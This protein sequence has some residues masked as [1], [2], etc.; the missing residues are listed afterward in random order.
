MAVGLSLLGVAINLLVTWRTDV[1]L[2]Q[3]AFDEAVSDGRQMLVAFADHAVRLL[4]YGDSHLR[5]ARAVYQR[6]GGSDGFRDFLAETKVMHSESLFVATTFSDNDGQIVFD[7]E[8][9]QVPNV[10]AAGLDYFTFFQTHDDDVAYIDPTRF[11]RVWQ[12]YLF[13][14]VRRL[15]RNGQ[16]DGVAILNM[17]PEHLANFTRQFDLGPNATYAILTLDHR[18]IVRQPMAPED[19][20]GVP[21]DGLKLWRQLGAAPTGM[22]RAVSLFDGIDRIY[23]YQ[24]LADYPLVVQ[25]GIA[26]KDKLAD[27]AYARIAN[28]EQAGAFTAVVLGFCLLVIVILRKGLGRNKRID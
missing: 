12:Q 9:R 23:L 4:D 5:A 14:I 24:K 13:R 28:V 11:G 1:D 6:L 21:Q 15:S 20:Y 19:A 8:K 10:T 27:L 2:R 18:L 16:F 7:S 25:V 26:E 17:R 3:R 22:Y